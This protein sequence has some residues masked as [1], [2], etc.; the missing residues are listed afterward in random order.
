MLGARTDRQQASS[1]QSG[2]ELHDQDSRRKAEALSFLLRIRDKMRLVIEIIHLIAWYLT[3]NDRMRKVE[4]NRHFYNLHTRGEGGAEHTLVPFL[5][6]NLQHAF[7]KKQ[8]L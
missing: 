2:W 1:A 4:K 8:K 7:F 3:K 6:T 5:S